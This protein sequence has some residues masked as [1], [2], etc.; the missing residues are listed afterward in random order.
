MIDRK[1]HP[2]QLMLAQPIFWACAGIFLYVFLSL[3]ACKKREG[4][5]VVSSIDS[6]SYTSV[7]KSVETLISDSGI[8]KYKLTA[9]IWYTYDQPQKHWYF[10]EGLYVEQFDTLFM[11]QASIKA[12]TAYYHQDRKLWEL[13]GNVEV[14]NREGQRYFGN[15]L[16]WDENAAEVY[17]H[18]KSL[19][20][21]ADGQLIESE[22]GFR[23]NQSMTRY[24]LYSSHG[25]MDFEDKPMESP[26]S[27]AHDPALEPDSI[28][29]ITP[30]PMK[31]N[32][33][34]RQETAISR[35]DEAASM[36]R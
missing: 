28:V 11:I 29:P 30:Q 8:T 25:H 18:E 27:I 4:D 24:V 10:P 19:I 16:Y 26:D 20:V 2:K 13:I 17:S 22:Y 36:R 3:S 34:I 33:R 1:G 5:A 21:P 35:K 7:T 12:D 23:S 14:L 31:Q 32:K 9:P 15:S 6:L